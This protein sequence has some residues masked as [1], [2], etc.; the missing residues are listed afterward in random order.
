MPNLVKTLVKLIQ[1]KVLDESQSSIGSVRESRYIFHGPPL[2]IMEDVFDEFMLN[3]GISLSKF[4]DNT[5]NKI[6]V[7]R[8][9][10]FFICMIGVCS[11]SK[12]MYKSVSF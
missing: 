9:N 7:L 10:I 11:V 12:L 2:T 6:A 3:G 1:E 4:D 5:E 8:K